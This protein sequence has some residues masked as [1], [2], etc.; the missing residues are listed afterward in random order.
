[1]ARVTERVTA[2]ACGNKPQA[3]P[4]N[5]GYIGHEVPSVDVLVVDDNELNARALQRVLKSRCHVVRIAVD[6]A[7]ALDQLR[8]RR[9]DV[10]ICDFDLGPETSA[11]LLRSVTVQHPGV[12]RIL[13]SA[14]R[15]ELWRELVDER[16]IDDTIAK[17]ASTEA[18]L[19]ALDAK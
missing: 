7:G 19:H 1:V 13:Y 17:P 15:P 8:A 18:I 10:L 14:S 5:T 4:R 6:V 11:R 12:R 9:P 16:L 3:P 2:G